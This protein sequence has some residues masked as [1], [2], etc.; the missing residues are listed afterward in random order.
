[1]PI[2]PKTPPKS[3]AGSGGVARGLSGLSVRA[4]KHRQVEIEICRSARTPGNHETTARICDLVGGVI[5]SPITCDDARTVI[6]ED[7]GRRAILRKP[8]HRRIT[9]NPGNVDN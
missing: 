1:M 2:I 5:D 6:C 3:I 7:K 8:P 4:N 9:G